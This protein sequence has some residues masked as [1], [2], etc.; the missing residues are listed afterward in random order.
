MMRDSRKIS[1]AALVI[2]LAHAG[3][4]LCQ[5]STNPEISGSTPDNLA[6]PSVEVFTNCTPGYTL[7]STLNECL[8][9]E[10][11]PSPGPNAVV[12]SSIGAGGG[13]GGGGGST[14]TGVAASSS[15]G[16]GAVASGTGGSAGGGSSTAA[17][18][19]SCPLEEI[20]Y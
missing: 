16:T 17:I 2:A 19:T 14:S 8:N 12:G 15:G 5:E 6:L 7:D 1:I 18:Q 9:P 20:C 3:A 13:G 4:A 11:Q 10:G